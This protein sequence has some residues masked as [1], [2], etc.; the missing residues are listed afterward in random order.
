MQRMIGKMVDAKPTQTRQEPTPTIM[1]FRRGSE[2]SDAPISVNVN[3]RAAVAV[4]HPSRRGA[5]HDIVVVDK[6]IV[7]EFDEVN[8]P[9]IAHAGTAIGVQPSRIALDVR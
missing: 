4:P 3:F 8:V 5:G 7:I 2:M 6:S 9:F 1:T